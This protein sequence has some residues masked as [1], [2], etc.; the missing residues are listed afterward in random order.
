M[1]VKTHRAIIAA[2]VEI[3]EAVGEVPVRAHRSVRLLT[4][5]IRAA[6]L[7]EQRGLDKEGGK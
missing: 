3:T 7:I 5:Y 1:T 2:L 6:E 4:A